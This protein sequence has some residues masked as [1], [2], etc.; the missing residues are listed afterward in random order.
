M[1]NLA[2]TMEPNAAVTLQV[3]QRLGQP[4]R[5]RNGNGEGNTDDN[6]EGSG[7]NTG[8]APMTLATFLKV[9]PPS[10][11]GSTNST[12]ADNWFQAMERALQ[13]QHVPHNQYVE[14]TTYQHREDGQ[15]WWQAE[16]HLLQLQNAHVP[17][18]VFQTAFYKKYFSESAREVKEM[19]LLQLEQGSLSVAEYTSKFEELCRFSMEIR[20]AV[21]PMEI[22]IFFD[23]VNKARMVEE[24]AKTVASS[25]DTHGVNTSRERDNNLGP[26]GQ[27]LKK[28]G[29]GKR[30]RAYSPNMKC[31]ECGNY[32]PNRPC[33]LDKKLCYKCGAP[34][35]LVRDC[36]LRRTPEA[37]RSQ[38]QD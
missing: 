38:Q 36:P 28:Y 17:W 1:A 22:R 13:A 2:N 32:H 4:A 31:Q 8:G 33:Q 23:L 10:F 27:N 25:R 3:V 35:H 24:N 15:H 12:E 16:C 14:F 9:H 7:D 11:K 26:W 21:A 6:A 19:E 20:M 18:D 30:S 5:N 34:G 29:E 37:G